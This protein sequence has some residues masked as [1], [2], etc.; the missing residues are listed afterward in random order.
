MDWELF[1]KYKRWHKTMSAWNITI[2]KS[3]TEESEILYEKSNN[4]R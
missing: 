4:Y 3:L 1:Q 2:T